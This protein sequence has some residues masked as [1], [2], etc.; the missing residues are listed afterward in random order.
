[1]LPSYDPSISIIIT[2]SIIVVKWT[3]LLLRFICWFL[4]LSYHDIASN[5]APSVV[6]IAVLLLQL[7]E[8]SWCSCCQVKSRW[9]SLTYWMLSLPY[10]YLVADRALVIAVAVS[11]ILSI[12][13]QFLLPSLLPSH[14][15]HHFVHCRVS[16]L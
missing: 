3:I 10:R 14:W 11:Y 4:I 2:P 5:V 9:A 16:F 1:M 7:F 12:F 6:V 13:C 15:F 8:L